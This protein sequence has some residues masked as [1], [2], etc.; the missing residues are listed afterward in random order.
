MVGTTNTLPNDVESL[1]KLLLAERKT[2]NRLQKQID[3]LFES[4][5][6]PVIN[7]LAHQAKRHQGKVSYLMKPKIPQKKLSQ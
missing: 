4:I 7:A 3:E 2:V 1:K 5:R 6:L